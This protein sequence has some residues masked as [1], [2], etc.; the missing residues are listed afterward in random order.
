LD[1][2]LSLV[3]RRLAGHPEGIQRLIVLWRVGVI[4]EIVELDDCLVG[5]F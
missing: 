1:H 2:L 4:L 5:W 3:I